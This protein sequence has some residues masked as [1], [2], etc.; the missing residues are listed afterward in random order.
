MTTFASLK[1]AKKFGPGQKG[2]L[3]LAREYGPA[4]VC[5][6]HRHDTNTGYRYTTVELVVDK[7]P[8]QGWDARVVGV[9]I[10]YH[11]KSSQAQARAHGAKW[12]P[13][14]RVW[15]MTLG[16]VRTLGMEDR[17]VVP[18]LAGRVGRKE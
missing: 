3:K 11:E 7:A 5:V 1:V 4:L 17:V 2:A 15:R 9:R 13:Q 8:I 12:D 18:S 14:A 16:A 6:R 10:G